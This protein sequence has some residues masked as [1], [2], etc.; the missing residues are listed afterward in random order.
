MYNC[1]GYK[2]LS[3]YFKYDS[4]DIDGIFSEFFILQ[5]PKEWVLKPSVSIL[6]S[7]QV[8][9]LDALAVLESHAL[10]NTKTGDLFRIS[11]VDIG[12]SLVGD[13]FSYECFNYLNALA[14]ELGQIKGV[15]PK[16]I[17]D[18]PTDVSGVY[19]HFGDKEF[20]IQFFCSGKYLIYTEALYTEDTVDC[21]EL[22]QNIER[23]R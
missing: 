8:N 6:G 2:D 5:F 22:F 7:E 16:G 1:P 11:V 4:S 9:V 10:E 20:F 19:G 21:F 18:E 12:K 17:H 23:L 14:A 3:S 15:V 13:E